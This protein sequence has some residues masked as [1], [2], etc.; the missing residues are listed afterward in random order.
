MTTPWTLSPPQCFGCFSSTPSSR[1]CLLSSWPASW[2]VVDSLLSVFTWGMG[3]RSFK[4]RRWRRERKGKPHV[5]LRT[6]H[7]EPKKRLGLLGDGL[8]GGQQWGSGPVKPTGSS[9]SLPALSYITK[10][11]SCPS[12]LSNSRLQKGEASGKEEKPNPTT[13]AGVGK[14]TGAEIPGGWG[15]MW[16]GG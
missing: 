6:E 4:F 7:G 5:M 1:F 10:Q 13:Q 3:W 8:I 12:A 11:R 14:D 9:P 2:V 15:G 16:G